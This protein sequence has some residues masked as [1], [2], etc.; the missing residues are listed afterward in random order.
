MDSL[1]LHSRTV[2]AALLTLH[3][4]HRLPTTLVMAMD[5]CPPTWEVTPTATTMASTAIL[6]ALAVATATTTNMA[7]TWAVS[8][9]KYATNII[10][11]IV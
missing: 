11:K 6:T 8:K 10:T 9:R 5:T 2:T 3:T 4:A 7:V 1:L